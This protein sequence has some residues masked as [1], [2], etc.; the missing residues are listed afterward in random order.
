MIA[1]IAPPSERLALLSA[2]D[3]ATWSYAQ[4][5]AEIAAQVAVWRQIWP[6]ERALVFLETQNDVASIIALLSLRAADHA[7]VL[8]DG[9]LDPS[10]R[11]ALRQCYQPSAVVRS[12]TTAAAGASAD[13]EAS[14]I[15]GIPSLTWTRDASAQTAARTPTHPAFALGLT[16]SG[17]TGSPKVVRL[18]E[19]AVIA[20][21]GSI[22]EA[23][24][25]GSNDRAI[26]CL[27]LHYA[28]G[29]S[30]L[31]SHLAAG[32]S[33]V[34]TGLGFM[35]R[36]FW[37]AVKAFE[38]T[39]LAGVPYMY[40]MLERLGPERAL[41]PSVRVMTQAGG[42]LQDA[43]VA[44]LHAVMA[45]RDGRFH[46]MYGQTEATARIAVM[47]HAW[48]PSRLGSAGRVIPGGFLEIR[49]AKGNT[50]PCGEEGEVVYR[51]PNVMMGYA[52]SRADLALGDTQHGVL[53]TGD[54]GRLDH[55]GALWIT[56]R[57]KRMGK[58]F[59]VRIDLDALE[60]QLSVDAPTA[61][62]EGDQQLLVFTAV[63]SASQHQTTEPHEIAVRLAAQLR[64]QSRTIQVRAIAALPRTASGKVDYPA[65]RRVAQ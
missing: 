24:A 8:I 65:L 47:P 34:V 30:L 38:V 1:M 64:V 60:R 12:R 51:G 53:H 40:E 5:H 16:T 63:G 28:Y 18:T 11:E 36:A 31:T 54:I 25:I 44:R 46:V 52:E 39:S 9:S 22:V 57:L 6:L 13:H 19:A 62:I 42:R 56:G 26:T 35:D 4:L 3:G 14:A 59:G 27:P 45:A 55:D 43:A 23:L 58:L 32:A 7:V 61:V 15:P 29:L 33:L 37:S 20:N 49:D 48:I 41:P 17:S 2:I 50:V 10:T 21:A